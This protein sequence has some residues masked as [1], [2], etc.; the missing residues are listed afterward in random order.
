MITADTL[1]SMI[2]R[3]LANNFKE[4]SI[5]KNQVKQ[6]GKLP[7]F[8]V[9]QLDPIQER[10]GRG[11]YKK[12]LIINIR[13]ECE[14][15]NNSK[16]DDMAFNLMELFEV[17]EYENQVY[18]PKKMSQINSDGVMQLLIYFEIYIV[19]EMIKEP[20]LNELNT[21][22]GIKIGRRNI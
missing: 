11:K 10:I 13:Y 18:I 6:G 7:C 22:G 20:I 14:N 1:K 12:T 15:Q 3:T 19:K 16:N 17:I 8:F 2:C 21:E 4:Y 9:S 5:Y